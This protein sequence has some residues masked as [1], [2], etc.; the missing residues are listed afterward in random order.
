MYTISCVSTTI[1]KTRKNQTITSRDNCGFEWD[2]L[3]LAIG[4]LFSIVENYDYYQSGF[5][6]LIKK[7]GKLIVD[8][9]HSTPDTLW[10]GYAPK[11]GFTFYNDVDTLFDVCPGTGSII[12]TPGGLF[13]GIQITYRIIDTNNPAAVID[14][15][16]E[17]GETIL[18]QIN[19]PS[20]QIVTADGQMFSGEKTGVIILCGS[21]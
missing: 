17:I 21:C 6:D 13:E 9:R 1:S 15:R 2:T 20:F 12:I 19:N 14:C 4:N 5:C 11:C 7:L 3:T 10:E 8:K 18:R 16:K